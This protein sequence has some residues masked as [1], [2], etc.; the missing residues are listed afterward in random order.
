M[1]H[2]KLLISV[3]RI[4]KSRFFYISL[5]QKKISYSGTDQQRN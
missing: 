1:G 4:W 5:R 3:V 2:F